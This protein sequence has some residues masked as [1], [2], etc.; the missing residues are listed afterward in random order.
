MKM[1]LPR[2]LFAGEGEGQTAVHIPGRMDSPHLQQLRIERDRR[3]QVRH[4]LLRMQT[5][6]EY[7]ARY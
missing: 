3:M 2:E 5:T 7:E 1:D 6:T 4:I